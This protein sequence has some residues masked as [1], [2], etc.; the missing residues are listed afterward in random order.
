MDVISVNV[1]PFNVRGLHELFVAGLKIL[2]INICPRDVR[3]SVDVASDSGLTGLNVFFLESSLS[4]L[5][6]ITVLG[7]E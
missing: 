4:G 7:T 6:G 5:N 1:C 2:S 3:E